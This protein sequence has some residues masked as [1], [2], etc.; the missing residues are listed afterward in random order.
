MKCPLTYQEIIQAKRAGRDGFLKLGYYEAIKI[1]G[2][3]SDWEDEA[4]ATAAYRKAL[5]DL[6]A[7][8]VANGAVVPPELR[9]MIAEMEEEA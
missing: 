3:E 6:Q 4:I 1:V 5:M 8:R 9:Q 7:R 2:V